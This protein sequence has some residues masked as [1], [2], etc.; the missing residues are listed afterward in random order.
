LLSL[1]FLLL[2]SILPGFVSLDS[3]SHCSTDFLLG[4]WEA[5]V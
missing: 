3:H 5:T 1:H 4:H 2:L